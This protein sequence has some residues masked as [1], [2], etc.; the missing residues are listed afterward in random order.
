MINVP[1]TQDTTDWQSEYTDAGTLPVNIGTNNNKIMGTKWVLIKM[2]SS[3]ATEYPNDTLYFVS[4]NKYTINGGTER[5]YQL[6]TITAST[7]YD[8]SLYFFT[9]FNGSHFSGNI[10]HY[11]VEDGEMNNIE[12]HNMQ[13]TTSTVRAWFKK[14]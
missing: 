12:F 7:N 1:E 6:N 2:V 14:I 10:G 8:L 13:N 9:P 5:N 3:F 11:F 4:N